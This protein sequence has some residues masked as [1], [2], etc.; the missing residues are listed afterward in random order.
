LS[1]ILSIAHAVFKAHLALWNDM[2]GTVFLT[3]LKES[4]QQGLHVIYLFFPLPQILAQCLHAS[5]CLMLVIT[6][7]SNQLYYS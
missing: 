6:E 5:M 3:E 4:W 7:A 2:S 1:P